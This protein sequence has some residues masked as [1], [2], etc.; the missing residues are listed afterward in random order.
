M[1]MARRV[2]TSLLIALGVAFTLGGCAQSPLAAQAQKKPASESVTKNE[3]VPD[4]VFY[5]QLFALLASLK[6]SKDYQEQAS[7]TDDQRKTLEVIAEECQREIAKQ[8]AKA[9]IIIQA[10]R[11]KATD[12]QPGSPPPPEIAE[13]QRERDAIAPRYRDRLQQALGENAFKPVGEAATRI[14]HISIQRTQAPHS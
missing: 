9:Q 10:L 6:N 3:E 14:V 2:I 1:F 5:E 8:D 12:P 4:H 7:L 11:K 13:L